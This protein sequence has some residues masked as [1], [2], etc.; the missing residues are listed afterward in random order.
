MVPEAFGRTDR[1]GYLKMVNGLRPRTLEA[2]LRLHF[3]QR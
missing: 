2:M 3:I 1:A